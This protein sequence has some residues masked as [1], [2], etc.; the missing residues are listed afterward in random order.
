M[1][2]K[3]NI[4]IMYATSALSWGRFFIPVL[5]LFYIA[6]QVS[7]QELSII[8]SVFALAT[9]IFEV[10][11]GVIADLLGKK[12][13]LLISRA[14]YILEIFLIAFFNG[15]WIFL[16]AKIAS[17]I[18]VSLTSGTGD[19]LI[20]DTLKKQGREKE[21]K[22]I[23]GILYMITGTS[24]A[25]VF[26]IGAFLFTINYKLPAIASLPLVILAFI[27]TFF[28][29]E[30]YKNNKKVNSK[31][32]FKHLKEAFRD[33]YKS[34]YVKYI[35]FFSMFV[36]IS[37]QIIF[38]LVS[39]YLN[40]IKIPIYLIGFIS[41][42]SAMSTVYASKKA[43]KIENKLGERNSL[44]LMG[45]FSI[46]TVFLFSITIPYLGILFYFMISF[47]WGFYLVLI[48]DYI[49]KSIKTSHRATMI[50][51]KN[52]FNNLGVFIL[53]PL[54]G[55]L[56][57]TQS[58]SFAFSILGFIVLGGFILIELLWFRKSKN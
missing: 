10:P 40:L 3:R 30:P 18:G 7:L 38:P 20:Y 37:V 8:F 24:M 41:F 35:A 9:L 36:F 34:S 33:F 12:K 15:F 56:I 1:Q 48:N 54:I 58:M 43:H 46:V 53:F 6:S 25:F 44:L 50:S 28:L 57:A 11:S 2:L 39:A 29:E 27:L 51:I 47:I 52:F 26:I 13:T 22:R 45:L 23:S 16:I 32:S 55:Y 31:N 21:H 5:A 14:F 42:L 4:P 17:G 49:N 19:A